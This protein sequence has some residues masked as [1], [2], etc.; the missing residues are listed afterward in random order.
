[1]SKEHIEVVRRA[2]AAVNERDVDGYLA[3]CTEDVELCTPFAEV[4]GLYQGPGGIRRFFTDVEDAGPA[5]RLDLERL[6]QVQA[7]G[8]VAFIRGHATWRV[9][10]IPTEVK[11]ANVYDFEGG[12]IRRVRIFSDRQ[13]ALDAGLSD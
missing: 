6:E 3:C 1:M 2:I 9:S 4:T 7:G 13:Q 5:F 11:T 8:V 10:G 12:R